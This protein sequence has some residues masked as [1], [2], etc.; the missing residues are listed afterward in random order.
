[1]IE[2]SPEPQRV[3]GIH[4]SVVESSPVFIKTMNPCSEDLKQIPSAQ[5]VLPPSVCER[6]T[7]YAV[8]PM[9]FTKGDTNLY[10]LVCLAFLPL[11]A[12]FCRYCWRGG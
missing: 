5:S 1:M 6:F 4:F 7:V 8:L 12:S 11:M 2:K 10:M 3:S 9:L